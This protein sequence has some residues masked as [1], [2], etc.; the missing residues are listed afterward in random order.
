MP[1][2]LIKSYAGA[3]FVLVSYFI[4]GKLC[5][6]YFHKNHYQKKSKALR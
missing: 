6:T 5:Y 2:L 1:S 3:V 4:V